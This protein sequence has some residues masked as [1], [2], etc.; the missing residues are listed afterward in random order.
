LRPISEADGEILEFHG[1]EYIEY[2]KMTRH[3]VRKSLDL[4]ASSLISGADDAANV[5]CNPQ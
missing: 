1:T 3:P 5:R 4:A 2:F